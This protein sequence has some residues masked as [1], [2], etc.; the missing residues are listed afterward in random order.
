[1]VH[2]FDDTWYMVQK[3]KTISNGTRGKLHSME[4]DSQVDGCY[5]CLFFVGALFLTWFILSGTIGYLLYF[6]FIGVSIVCVIY[7]VITCCFTIYESCKL[8][9]ELRR[10]ER[11]LQQEVVIPE[12]KIE[13]VVIQN[14]NHISL[15]YKYEP[16]T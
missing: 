7:T 13:I 6:V 10:H 3:W 8:S 9:I 16:E 14:P 5:I 4:R 11:R 15:G 12:P 2:A 1:M